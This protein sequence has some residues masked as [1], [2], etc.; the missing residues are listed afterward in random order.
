MTN[1][2][3]NLD[4]FQRVSNNT[5]SEN[6][7]KDIHNAL[8]DA[9][10]AIEKYSGANIVLALPETSELNRVY[11]LKQTHQERRPGIYIFTQENPAEYLNVGGVHPKDGGGLRFDGQE[12]EVMSTDGSRIFVYSRSDGFKFLGSLPISGNTLSSFAQLTID[13]YNPTEI[14][15]NSNNIYIQ[16]GATIY[17]HFISLTEVT[18]TPVETRSLTSTQVISGLR[19][20]YDYFVSFTN[21]SPIKFQP[22]LLDTFEFVTVADNAYQTGSTINI[23]A[24]LRHTQALK[25]GTYYVAQDGQSL[26]ISP[27]N[28]KLIGRCIEN[29]YLV[30]V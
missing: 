19:P 7:H 26:T 15:F 28:N 14:F 6:A 21:D 2:P 9:V 3:N 11:T 30:Q 12:L 13:N 25:G 20:I 17:R 18:P 1:L 16:V 24:S 4:T 23:Q 27:T 8:A 22:F 10:E 5:R 29:N